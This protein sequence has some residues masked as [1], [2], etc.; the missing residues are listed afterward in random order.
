MRGWPP[1]WRGCPWA[2]LVVSPF[3]CLAVALGPEALVLGE[4]RS[5][6]DDGLDVGI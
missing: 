6:L 3:T 2:L 1:A 4:N 5:R